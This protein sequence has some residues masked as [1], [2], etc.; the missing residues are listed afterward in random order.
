MKY[1]VTEDF[2]KIAKGLMVYFLAMQI[3]FPIYHLIHGDFSWEDTIG[4]FVM[5]VVVTLLLGVIYFFGSQ[6]P[7]KKNE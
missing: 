5:S 4:F 1:R 6:I 7:K 3:G 2:K